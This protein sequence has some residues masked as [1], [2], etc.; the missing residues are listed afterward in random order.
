MRDLLLTKRPNTWSYGQPYRRAPSRTFLD[1]SGRSGESGRQ[2]GPVALRIRS[3]TFD[4]ADPYRLAQ[5][6]SQATGFQEDPDNPNEPG[7]PE[8]LLMSPDGSVALLFLPVRRP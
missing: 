2:S 6:W 4:C 8:G 5:F 3:I 7:D 1:R